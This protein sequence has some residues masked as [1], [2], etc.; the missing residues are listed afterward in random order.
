MIKTM[1]GGAAC[2]VA[3]VARLNTQQNRNILLSIDGF[4]LYQ[5][6]YFVVPAHRNSATLSDPA[7]IISLSGGSVELN[8]LYKPPPKYF[9]GDFVRMDGSDRYL[10]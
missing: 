8:A 5:F 10:E 7:L 6:V 1:F 3:A 2:A 4:H 9:C